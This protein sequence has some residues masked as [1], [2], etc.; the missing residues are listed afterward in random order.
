LKRPVIL[1][2]VLLVLGG[3]LFALLRATAERGGAAGAG[4]AAGA[5]EGFSPAGLL[6][7]SARERA[8]AK[9][10][11]G[12]ALEELDR[13]DEAERAFQDAAAADSTF[14]PPVAHLG[15][16]RLVRGD[17][18]AARP[19]LEKALALDP[20]NAD[21][22]F[23]LAFVLEEDR[24][25]ERAEAEYRSAIAA[26]S[27]YAEAYNNLGHL[28]IRLGRAEEAV[29]V[30]EEGKRRDPESAF[31]AKNLG[32]AY[33]RARRWNEARP[34]LERALPLAGHDP[35]VLLDLAC[36]RRAAGNEPEALKLFRQYES[37][38]RDPALRAAGEQ[39]FAATKK[40]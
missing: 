31:V 32:R 19:L 18:Q 9:F 2:V 24:E 13:L 35:E 16:L 29:V 7:S 38:Q 30:L 14:A 39:I 10:D 34:L 36:V 6:G 15:A 12:K 1:F 25:P 37:I 5:G 23:H 20:R 8:Q 11:D 17:R 33:A 22:H 4:R 27:G 21:A 40:S 26:D 28:L 3:A